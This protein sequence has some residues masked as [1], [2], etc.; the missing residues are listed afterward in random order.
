MGRRR[1]KDWQAVHRELMGKC[2]KEAI[3]RVTEQI[4]GTERKQSED[5][6]KAKENR[7]MLAMCMDVLKIYAKQAGAKDAPQEPPQPEPMDPKM[8][9]KLL[10]AL[11]GE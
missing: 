2:V 6:A 10:A 1:K 11:A 7:D 5:T 3:K 8:A 4:K 9:E